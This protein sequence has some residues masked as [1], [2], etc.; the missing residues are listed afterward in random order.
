MFRQKNTDNHNYKRNDIFVLLP[1]C[2]WGRVFSTDRVHLNT[3]FQQRTHIKTGLQVKYTEIKG[4]SNDRIVFDASKVTR[5]GSTNHLV[6]KLLIEFKL[7]LRLG[8]CD[9][10]R[11]PGSGR[12][13]GLSTGQYPVRGRINIFGNRV[14]H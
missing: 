2:L 14:T 11:A 12:L 13:T 9:P 3:S 7:S 1:G 4:D 6:K 5:N 10:T 8:L